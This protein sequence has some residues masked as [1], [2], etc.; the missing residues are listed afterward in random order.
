M[1][2]LAYQ[3]LQLL[4]LQVHRLKHCVKSSITFQVV[5]TMRIAPGT[6][7]LA[8]YA[9]SEAGM[10]LPRI[11]KKVF[12]NKGRNS[13]GKGGEPGDGQGSPGKGGSGAENDN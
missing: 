3:S 10:P 7:L 13:K 1:L 8:K 4:T 5:T 6:E 12:R 9:L 11:E 2:I